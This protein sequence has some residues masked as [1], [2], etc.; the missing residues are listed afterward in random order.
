MNDLVRQFSAVFTPPIQT[1]PHRML[2]RGRGSIASLEMH[3]ISSTE[4]QKKSAP[5]S[6][7][8]APYQTWRNPLP[9]MLSNV[10]FVTDLA[11]LGALQEQE[12]PVR[13]AASCSGACHSLWKGNISWPLLVGHDPFAAHPTPVE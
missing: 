11:I 8:P 12:A 6:Q 13:R 7:P 9:G 3:T 4:L 5:L 10:Q 2:T 1:P